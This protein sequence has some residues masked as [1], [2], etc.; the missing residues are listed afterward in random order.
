MSDDEIANELKRFQDTAYSAPGIEFTHDLYEIHGENS[1]VAEVGQFE[2]LNLQAGFG[3]LRTPGSDEALYTSI[4]LMSGRY[5]LRWKR[6]SPYRPLPLTGWWKGLSSGE[7]Y[8]RLRSF[9]RAQYEALEFHFTHGLIRRKEGKVI[10]EAAEVESVEGDESPWVIEHEGNIIG[11]AV[12][13]FYEGEGNPF[14]HVRSPRD[15]Y[16]YETKE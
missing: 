8:A 3:F 10:G 7:F 6:N 13:R 9:D 11:L 4:A 5:R 1:P 2:E 15:P 12:I 14:V 16:D